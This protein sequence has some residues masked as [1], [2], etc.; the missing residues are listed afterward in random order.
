MCCIIHVFTLS[1]WIKA[2]QCLFIPSHPWTCA[3]RLHFPPLPISHHDGQRLHELPCCL[4]DTGYEPNVMEVNDTASSDICFQESLDHT[5]FSS[6]F[7]MDDDQLGKLLA[8]VHRDYADYRRPEGVSVSPSS[9]SVM[10]DRTGELVEERIAEERRLGHEFLAAQA[11]QGH[12]ILRE[13]LLRQQQDFSWSS[14]TRFYNNEGWVHK[15]E[16][17]RGSEDHY[18]II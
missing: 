4:P 9:V 13:G 7:Y 5:A 1:H 2:S 16:V 11:E 6:D 12:R 14:S 17:H 10:V 15:P 18:G 8:D 3:V